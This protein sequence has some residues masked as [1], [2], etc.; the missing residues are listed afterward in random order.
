M[1][2]LAELVGYSLG[3]MARD[4]RYLQRGCVYFLMGGWKPSAREMFSVV[5]LI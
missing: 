4:V 2:A 3:K 5:F 1:V